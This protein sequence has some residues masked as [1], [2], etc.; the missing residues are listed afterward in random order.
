MTS[1]NWAAPS[2][3]DGALLDAQRADDLD[4]YLAVLARLDVF[5]P[6]REDQDSKFSVRK[7]VVKL[8]QL[9]PYGQLNN[10]I[11][12]T[13]KS[14]LTVSMEYSTTRLGLRLVLPVHTRALVPDERP[15]GVFYHQYMF[16]GWV[17]DLARQRKTMQ[18]VINPGTPLEREINVG[19]AAR[20]LRRNPQAAMGRW[21]DLRQR[22][23]TVF[24]EPYQ[25]ELARS[26]ACG[27]HLALYNAVPWNTM[28]KPYLDYHSERETL[29]EWWGVE[30]PVQWQNQVDALLD[31]ENPRP[32]DLVLGIRTSRNAGTHPTGDLTTDTAQ[33]TEAI[34]SWCRDRDTPQEL[35]QELTD[36]AQWVTRCEMW[37]RRDGILP[38][39]AT[40]A[41]QGGWDWGRCVNMARWGL[42]SGYCDR[43]AAEQI[44][45]YAGSLCARA[46]SEWSEL[47]AAYVLG[48]VVKMGRQG[49]PEQ[50][51][52]ES[53]GLH[54][55]LMSDPGSPWVNLK[56]R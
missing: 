11:R 30:G 41:T 5:V 23:R 16:P 50:T 46:Y 6:R 40:V 14:P 8:N 56:L 21:A 15:E 7:S 44:V 43:T 48:R 32:V 33:L 35:W 38:P 18:L 1:D 4:A 9:T 26:L 37:M 13:S 49:N 3:E 53:L 31:T 22:V 54:R 39:G 10:A 20:W 25:G 28:G 52:N 36:I 47:S 45:R 19:K 42:A 2:V 17:Q 34:T 55:T 24:N 12:G 27:A 51:Y 29:Q